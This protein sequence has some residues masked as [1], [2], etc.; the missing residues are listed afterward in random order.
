MSDENWDISRSA[1]LFWKATWT[2]CQFPF[3]SRFEH[4]AGNFAKK[5][6]DLT[7]NIGNLILI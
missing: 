5:V 4:Q 1:V 3:C 7:A 2:V 6:M